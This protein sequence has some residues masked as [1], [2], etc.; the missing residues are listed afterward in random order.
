V[1]GV[2]DVE[3]VLPGAALQLV[4]VQ[5]AVGEEVLL[6]GDGAAATASGGGA[7][8]DV[9]G[10]SVCCKVLLIERGEGSL[11]RLRICRH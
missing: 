8:R 5:V 10:T 7:A 2:D 11:V 1:C 9:G 6:P 4:F 3:H